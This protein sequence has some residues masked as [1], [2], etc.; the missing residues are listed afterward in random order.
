MIANGKKK[1]KSI[2]NL[3]VGN[4][5]LYIEIILRKNLV[6]RVTM[7]DGHYQ[8]ICDMCGT[9][10][11]ESTSEDVYK[12]TIWKTCNYCESKKI[13]KEDNKPTKGQK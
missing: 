12:D 4:V 10:Y 5:Q 8:K 9:L 3:V 2:G 7:V 11:E 13:L 1:I 6:R